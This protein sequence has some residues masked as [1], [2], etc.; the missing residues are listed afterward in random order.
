MPHCPQLDA[1]YARMGFE[2]IVFGVRSSADHYTA[3]MVHAT[4]PKIPAF[5]DLVVKKPATDLAT[6]IEAFCLSGI[7]G[8]SGVAVLERHEY[9][10]VYR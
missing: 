2:T 9:L 7:D 8:E 5:F 10:Q 6:S 1:L 4:S 3:P